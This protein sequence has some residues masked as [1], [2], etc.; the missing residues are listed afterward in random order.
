M[1]DREMSDRAFP[2]R[3]LLDVTAAAKYLSVSTKTIRRHIASGKVRA[4]KVR[5]VWFCPRAELDKLIEVKAPP[6]P[7]A[8]AA[9]AVDLSVVADLKVTLEDIRNLMKGI[10][11]RL[12]LISQDRESRHI[13]PDSAEKYQEAEFIRADNLKLIEEQQRLKKDLADLRQNGAKDLQLLKSKTDEIESY[14]AR[15]AS[16]ERGLNLLRGDLA[17]RD[18][19]VLRKDEIIRELK[20]RIN[21]LEQELAALKSGK[22]TG[23]LGSLRIA[24]PPADKKAG[25]T[26]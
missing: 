9:P 26:E 25:A 8:A 13:R 14:K 21:G 3:D 24:A 17:D 1:D 10:D 18:E 15:I 6:A 2:E 23:L 19:A 12:F 11:G 20:E 22:K 5:N 4:R 7:A 16:N